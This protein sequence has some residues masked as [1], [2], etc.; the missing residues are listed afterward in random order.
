MFPAVGVRWTTVVITRIRSS[1]DFPLHQNLVTGNRVPEAAR[2]VAVFVV[3][4]LLTA[5]CVGPALTHDAYRRKAVASLEQVHAT[6]AGTS[7]ALEAAVAGRSF[8]PATAVNVRQH[9]ETVS[10]VHTAFATRQPP[11]GTGRIR[12]AVVPVLSD[13]AALLAEIRI[14]ANRSDDAQLRRQRSQLDELSDRVDR[15]L[16]EVR[17]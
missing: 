6:I 11:P 4:S 3:F 1:G 9:E 12:A 15:A 2:L 5:A 16:R 10:W 8:S 7:I 14:A 13:A 17:R